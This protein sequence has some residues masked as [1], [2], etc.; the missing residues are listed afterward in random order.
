MKSWSSRLMVP[1]AGLAGVVLFA[2]ATAGG[3]LAM[4]TA[5]ADVPGATVTAGNASLAIEAPGDLDTTQLYPGQTATTSFSV[6]NTGTVPL[7]LRVDSLTWA[8]RSELAA[9]VTVRVWEQTAA[10]CERPAE[11]LAWS[12]REP[13]AGGL[14]ITINPGA[15]QPMCL[16]G[17]MSPTAPSSVQGAVDQL[18]LTVEGAQQR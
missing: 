8:N 16:A 4:W 2:V 7:G 12:S 6:H 14:G 15:N 5:Q 9:A 18:Q 1:A 11:N 3:T 17:T 13:A 10:G